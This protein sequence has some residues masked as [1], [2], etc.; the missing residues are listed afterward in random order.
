MISVGLREPCGN[1]VEE[2]DATHHTLTSRCLKELLYREENIFQRRH[3]PDTLS[4][5]LSLVLEHF[6]SQLMKVIAFCS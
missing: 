5:A 4:F 1:S 2:E 6:L 3:G